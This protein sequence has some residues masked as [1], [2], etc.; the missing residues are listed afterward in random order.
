MEIRE[1][2]RGDVIVLVIVG[3]LD[4]VTYVGLQEKVASMLQGD[5][6]KWVFDLSALEYISSAGLRVFLMAAKESQK[7]QGNMALCSMRDMVRQVFETSGMASLFTIA[8]SLDEALL[9]LNPK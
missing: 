6:L 2:M 7:K 1:S 3:R 8:S 4:A 9:S 5:R